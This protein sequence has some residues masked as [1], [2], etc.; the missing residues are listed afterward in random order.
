[1]MIIGRVFNSCLEHW[2]GDDDMYLIENMTDQEFA[3]YCNTT[4]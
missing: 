1:M 4:L 2:L 3:S